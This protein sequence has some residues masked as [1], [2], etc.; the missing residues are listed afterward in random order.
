MSYLKIYGASDDLIEIEGDIREEFNFYPDDSEDFR[1]LAISDGTLLRMNYDSD[2]IWRIHKVMSGSATFEKAEGSVDE[3]TPDIV[4]L[5]GVD[6]RWVVVGGDA[7][8]TKQNR[9]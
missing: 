6:I 8:I 5:T 2:G 3:D 7:A 9:K 4:R 1:Y